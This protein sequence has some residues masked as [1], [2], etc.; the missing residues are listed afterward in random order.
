MRADIIRPDE[1]T[2]ADRALWIEQ[3]ALTPEFRS[4]LLGPDFAEA[5]ARRRSDAAIAVY[6]QGSETVGFLA[7]HRRHG[8][9]ARPI[10]SPFSDYHALIT[11]PEPAFDGASALVAAGLTTFPFDA[12]RDPWGLFDH[13]EAGEGHVVRLFD[14][15][16]ALFARIRAANTKKFKNY[17]RL[18]RRMA[19]EM[20]PLTLT[21]PDHS[22]AAFAQ[23]LAWK[24]EQFARSGLHDVL[25]PAWSSG[26]MQDMFERRDGDFRGLLLTLRA[27]ETLVAGHFGVRLDRVYHPWIASM[28]PAV[29]AYSPGHA[30][31]HAAI[32]A[33]PGLGLDGYD[34]SGGHD[35]YK[36]S[37]AEERSTTFA[38]LGLAASTAGRRAGRL[39]LALQG[40]VS[41]LSERPQ[42]LVRRAGRRLDQI[43]SV[44]L[45]QIGRLRGVVS[46]LA[47][48]RKRFPGG[49]HA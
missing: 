24:R 32:S 43:A 36:G 29:S 12:L 14:D 20:G 10:G 44:E 22:Q 23:V 34:L 21:G 8:G 40:A 38:G 18:A 27:G 31:M 28:D 47:A 2:S 1:L 49:D 25:G 33:M 37:Y 41:R 48:S 15:P 7:H 30:F 46:A 19:E 16:E 13:A 17:R 26:L 5:V 39:D 6:R 9:A 3:C 42:T 35:H 45:T 11:R 4:P